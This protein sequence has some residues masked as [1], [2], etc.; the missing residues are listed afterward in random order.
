MN[1][2]K[3]YDLFLENKDRFIDKNSNL[4][5]MQKQIIKDFFK[6]HPASEN[7]IDW[8]KSDILAYKDFEKIFDDANNTK[9]ALK[10]ASKDNPRLLFEK[11]DDCKIVGENDK[12]IFVLPLSYE[13]CVWMDSFNCGGAGAKW[14]IGYEQDK[15]YYK[16]YYEDGYAFILAF[17]KYPTDINANLKY[18]I[19][20][21]PIKLENGEDAG[22]CWTQNDDP[23]ETLSILDKD[24]KN[25]EKLT[26]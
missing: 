25:V 26:A 12:F 24:R 21:D 23:K 17:N 10:R 13:A 19:Q 18:M 5:P 16:Q 20:V 1:Y 6:D 11:R 8:N 3:I 22:K 4:D 14:C 15:K 2:K 7:Q 9:N